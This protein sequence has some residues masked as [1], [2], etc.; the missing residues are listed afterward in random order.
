MVALDPREELHAAAFELVAA[1]RGQDGV[2][3]RVEIGFEED[4]AEGP[5]GQT[6]PVGRAFGVPEGLLPADLDAFEA[7]VGSMLAPAGG[8]RVSPIARELAHAVLHSP[9]AP[10]APWLAGVATGLYAWTLWPSIGLLPPTVREDYG[11]AWGR[12]ERLVS[13]WLVATWRAWRPLL[14]ATFRQMPKALAADRRMLT[15]G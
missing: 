11:L 5:H 3:H 12:R 15:V 13:A 4:M 10:L 1:D 8:V 14:P 9:L 7:Y 6:R 2:P